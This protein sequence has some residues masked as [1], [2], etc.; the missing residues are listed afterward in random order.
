MSTLRKVLGHQLREVL[1]GR[2]VLGYA[3]FFGLCTWGLVHFGGGTSRALPSLATVIVLVV[4]MVCLLMTTTTVYHGGDFV[5]LLLS[6]PIGRRP[7]FFGLYL[8]IAV[9]LAG[10]FL[11][12][13][14][15]PLLLT[16]SLAGYLVPVLI[17][18]TVGVLLTGVFTS[19]GLLLALR[20]DDPAKGSGVAVLLWL[21]MAVLYDG[22][23]LFVA[24][25]W[26]AYP[27]ETAMLALMALNPVDVGRVLVLIALDASAL[28][29]YTG[30]VFQDFFGGLRGAAV[31]FTCLAVWIVAPGSLALRTFRRKD[32]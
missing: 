25:R 7:L 32:F 1:R 30:A 22:V 5:E 18:A 17:L 16:S 14:V 15:L 10:A 8:G 6:H 11:S 21:V 19:I 23:V 9:P 20:I 4:P 12:G 31:A 2:A 13:L 26:A 27:L 29:G 3:L 24:F 28:M